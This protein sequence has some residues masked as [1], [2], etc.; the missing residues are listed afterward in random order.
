M[1]NN[2]C[3]YMQVTLYRTVR[4]MNEIIR[5]PEFIPA[6]FPTTGTNTGATSGATSTAGLG[7][8]RA[9]ERIKWHFENES[10]KSQFMCI[11]YSNT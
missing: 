1:Q 3:H 4:Q 6:F 11:H 9:V 10:F 8:F 2:W 5:E 7:D